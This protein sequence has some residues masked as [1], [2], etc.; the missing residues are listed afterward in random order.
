[1]MYCFSMD[2]NGISVIFRGIAF[3]LFP[4]VMRERFGQF[5]HI[6]IPIGFCQNGSCRDVLK[7]PIPLDNTLV[8]NIFER[9]KPIAIHHNMFGSKGELFQCQM[10]GFYGGIQDIDLDQFLRAIQK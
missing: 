5:L 1:M 2:T 10:H 9:L 7:F 3:V 6:I 8:R 4:S